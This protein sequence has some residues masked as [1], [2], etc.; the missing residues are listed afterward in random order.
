MRNDTGAAAAGQ[1]GT[2]RTREL[3][4]RVRAIPISPEDSCVFF[5][6]RD[7]CVM[8]FRQCRY[9]RFGSF[10]KE[11]DPGLCKFKK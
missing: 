3:E 6:R 9:C 11:N 5:H 8:G 1:V 2:D 10:E 7:G 4:M